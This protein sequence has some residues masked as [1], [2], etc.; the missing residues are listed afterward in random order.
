MEGFHGFLDAA[1]AFPAVLFGFALVVVAVY[2]CAVL[3]GGAVI[4]GAEA[5]HGG[6]GVGSGGSGAHG[7]GTGLA[8]FGL[9][10]VPVTVVLSLLTAIAWF[11][12]L[13]GT[14]LFAGALPR[15]LTLPCALAAAWWG[16]RL[17]LRPLRRL[18]PAEEDIA[19]SDFTGRVC[20]IRTGRVGPGFGQAE[21]AASDGSTALV[22]VRAAG[23]DAARLMAGSTALLYHYD[24]EG[25]FFH[26]APFDPGPDPGP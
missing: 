26:V 3:L 21:V 9:G 23:T 5:P 14:A 12:S 7:A 1:L 18:T 2:W 16:T 4:P 8:A 13:A 6:E 25:E 11:V 10:G 19:R 17:L 15:L 20:T 22:Q 24:A